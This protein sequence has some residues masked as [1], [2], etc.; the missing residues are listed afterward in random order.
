MRALFGPRFAAEA[1]LIVAVAIVAGSLHFGVAGSVAAVLGAWV[2]MAVSEWTAWRMRR[3][4]PR[5][6]YADE[7]EPI[8]HEP[9]PQHVRVLREHAVPAIVPPKHAPEPRPAPVVEVEARVEVEPEPA[10]DPAPQPAP[11]PIAEPAP[12]PEPEP[13]PEPVA[14]DHGPRSWNLW[15]L[16][17]LVRS[18]AGADPVRDEERAYLLLYLRDFAGAD[19]TLP[20]DFDE[21]VRESFGVTA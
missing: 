1:A 19:G 7:P 17:R 4:R 12:E 13:V 8:V 18:H 10:L 6:Q 9:L 14:L 3:R 15:E 16:E 20:A 21:L 2:V 11:E 5:S